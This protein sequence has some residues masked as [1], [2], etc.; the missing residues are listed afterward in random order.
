MTVS[1]R[2]ELIRVIYKASAVVLLLYGLIHGLTMV[3]P[4]IPILDQTWRNL[5]YHV[6]MWY[7]M[8]VMVFTS[9]GYSISYL[10]TQDQKKDSQAGAV[11]AVG[12]MFGV[13]G[14]VTGSVWSRVTWYATLHSTDP[15]AWWGWDPKPT[16]ALIAVLMYAAYFLLRGS[17][18]EPVQKAR[19]S[20]VF[21]IFAAA[22]ILPLYYILPKV[23]GGLHPGSGEEGML[24]TLASLNAGTRI[25]LY[26]TAIGF[27]LLGFWITE[28]ITRLETAERK[29][30]DLD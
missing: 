10:N 8:L 17:I 13:A 22:L 11:A 29:I 6:P 24:A 18:D 26:P 23:L 27:I 9:A 16:F 25:V 28:L 15:G 2:K 19:I 14:L 5:F 4:R 12:I 7:A 3:I 20:A 21:N 30:N 1:N